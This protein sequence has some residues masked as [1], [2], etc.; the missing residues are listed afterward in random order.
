MG[1]KSIK[2]E[3]IDTLWDTAYLTGFLGCGSIAANIW[4]DAGIDWTLP[5]VAGPTI[6]FFQKYVNRLPKPR[7]SFALT[8]GRASGGRPV[9]YKRNDTWLFSRVRDFLSESREVRYRSDYQPIGEFY[10]VVPVTQRS[11]PVEVLETQ[12]LRFCK[13]AAE[14][15]TNQL[16]RNY[17]FRE[18]N[19]RPRSLYFA[20]IELLVMTELV[21]HRRQGSS[22]ELLY[23]PTLTVR[24]AKYRGLS[25]SEGFPGRTSRDKS[26]QVEAS[27]TSLLRSNE[28]Y[29]HI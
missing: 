24:H 17:F 5:L 25:L 19:Y 3:A 18:R 26:G 27:D 21:T 2:N 29:V 6:I 11:Q 15:N 12:L 13:I 9:R 16:S 20:C 8:T 22:G 23:P 1:R 4:F 10:W 28:G 7:T 14:R